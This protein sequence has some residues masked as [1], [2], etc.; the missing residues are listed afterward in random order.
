MLRGRL[1]RSRGLIAQDHGAA[2]TTGCRR[3]WPPVRRRCTPDVTHSPQ[4]VR[5]YDGERRSTWTTE[6]WTLC[7]RRRAK[8]SKISASTAATSIAHPISGPGTEVPGTCWVFR[9]GQQVPG[10]CADLGRGLGARRRAGWSAQMTRADAAEAGEQLVGLRA[11]VPP[12]GRIARRAGRFRGSPRWRTRSSR[13]RSE[14][15]RARDR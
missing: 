2:R 4:L 12:R 7:Y 8:T 10:T 5:K 1:D 15:A 11:Y 9:P 14:S 3:S 13:Q 6:S